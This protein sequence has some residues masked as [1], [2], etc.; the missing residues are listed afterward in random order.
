MIRYLRYF[1]VS[2]K[3]NTFPLLLDL[4]A[5]SNPILTR[6]FSVL[7]I[8]QTKASPSLFESLQGCDSFTSLTRCAPL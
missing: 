3:L 5:P 4:S 2:S 1:L 8:D 6:I 7:V